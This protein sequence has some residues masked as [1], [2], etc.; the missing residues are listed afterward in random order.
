[1]TNSSRD[2]V[3][4]ITMSLHQHYLTKGM[5]HNVFFVAT[6]ACKIGPLLLINNMHSLIPPVN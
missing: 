2:N 4:L 3:K 5:N 1:M 6:E